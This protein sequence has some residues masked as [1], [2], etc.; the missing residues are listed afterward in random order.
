MEGSRFLLQPSSIPAGSTLVLVVEQV[1][2]DRVAT[3]SFQVDGP[4]P[5]CVPSRR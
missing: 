3:T 2:E 4:A 1:D 5:A